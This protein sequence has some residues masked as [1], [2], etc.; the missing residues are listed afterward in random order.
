MKLQGM[1]QIRDIIQLIFFSRA[2]GGISD[3]WC[4][5]FCSVWIVG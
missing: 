3:C 2:C 5:S 1:H 4:I